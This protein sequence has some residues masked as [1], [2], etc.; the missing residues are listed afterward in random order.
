MKYKGYTSK[1][2]QIQFVRVCL[3]YT[4]YTFKRVHW[5][6]HSLSTYES[7]IST[8]KFTKEVVL[9]PLVV[10]VRV[11]YW[12]CLHGLESRSERRFGT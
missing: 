3:F 9:V 4:E 8:Y 12:V 7:D 2:Q 1:I 10:F 5:F 11:P 6:V